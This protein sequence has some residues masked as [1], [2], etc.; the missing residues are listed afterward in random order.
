MTSTTN[1]KK[2]S[3]HLRGFTNN[4]GSPDQLPPAPE[5]LMVQVIDGKFDTAQDRQRLSAFDMLDETT[6]AQAVL[7]AEKLL[8]VWLADTMAMIDYGKP[9]IKKM[10]D[11]IDEQRRRIKVIEVPE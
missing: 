5:S 9:V 1:R 7:E 3:V 8:D 4:E 2:V 6:Q 10:N 11:L